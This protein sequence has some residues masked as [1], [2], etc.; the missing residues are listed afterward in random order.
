MT[1]K[2][3]LASY[4]SRSTLTRRKIINSFLEGRWDRADHSEGVRYWAIYSHQFKNLNQWAKKTF[5]N[6]WKLTLTRHCL[7][8][9][10]A[11]DSN[12]LSVLDTYPFSCIRIPII[13]LRNRSRKRNLVPRVKFAWKGIPCARE[14]GLVRDTF[15]SKIKFP[16]PYIKWQSNEMWCTV[17]VLYDKFYLNFAQSILRGASDPQYII[18]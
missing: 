10:S 16:R 8:I 11:S 9:G 2:T 7:K 18:L 12:I 13:L 1:F 5:R 3:G 14:F 4:L 17:C 15:F 6:A